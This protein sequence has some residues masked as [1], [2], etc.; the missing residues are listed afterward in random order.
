MEFK[1]G[2]MVY[3]DHVNA[4]ANEI[5]KRLKKSSY[6]PNRNINVRR[7]KQDTHKIWFGK[8]QYI[9]ISSD[10][11]FSLFGCL[12]FDRLQNFLFEYADSMT[13][14]KYSRAIFEHTVKTAN[15]LRKDMTAAFSDML[16]YRGV[17]QE[18]DKAVKASFKK[19]KHMETK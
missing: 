13:G 14:S 2:L 16:I 1:K 8:N 11:K 10:G 18:I 6:F 9:R 12:A 17:V 19:Y 4:V 7:D 15:K 5:V 3:E